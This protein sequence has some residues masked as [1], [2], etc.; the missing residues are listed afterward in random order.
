MADMRIRYDEEMV[1]AGHPTKADTLN[2]LALVEAD[3]DG[4]GRW[5][6]LKAQNSAPSTGEDEGVLYTQVIGGALE[7]VFRG[8][9]DG[10]PLR[11]SLEGRGAFRGFIMGVYPLYGDGSSIKIAP[12]VLELGGEG[13][14]LPTAATLSPTLS[15]DSWHFIYVKAAPAGPTLTA[16]DFIV[17]T[18]APTQGAE[19]WYDTDGNRCIGFFY[20]EATPAIVPFVVSQ[21]FFLFETPRQI[22]YSTSP[23]G[24]T[25]TSV[26]TGFPIGNTEVLVNAQGYDSASDRVSVH[27][28]S[29]WV[30]TL[31]NDSWAA[32]QVK[33]GGASQVRASC[34]PFPVQTDTSGNIKFWCRDSTNGAIDQ[35]EI[36]LWGVGIPQ[37]MGRR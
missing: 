31:Y 1:G 22:Y 35:L 12:G 23:P 34:A 2:R 33:A 16:S 8:P 17:S 37:G 32:A 3:I 27:I 10:A 19:G 13:F 11:L 4:H 6:Y 9:A 15:G 29:G 24:G 14:K 36:R 18:T 21:N 5:R 28:E 25:L 7:L 30:S 26:A 20:A